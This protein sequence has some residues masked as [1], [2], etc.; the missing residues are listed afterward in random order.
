MKFLIRHY[1]HSVVV[2]VLAFALLAAVH[3]NAQSDALPSWNDGPAKQS[4]QNFVKAVTDNS[5]AKY[6][7]PQDRIATF[8]QDGTLWVEHP[9]Y[10]QAVFA[11][12]RLRELA[13]A[14]REW[15][16]R[17]PFKA[18]L[19][20]DRKAMSKFTEADWE[21]IVTVTHSGMGTEAFEEIVKKWLAQ[22]RDPR[23]HRPVSD[24]GEGVVVITTPANPLMIKGMLPGETRSY[25]QQVSV[26][27]LDDP[28]DQRYTGTL[29]GT[30]TYLGT[31]AVT[32]P[33]GTYTAGLFRLSCY[34]KVG[35]AHTQDTAYYFFAPG[36]GVVAMISQEDATAFWI[37]YIDTSSGK[38]LASK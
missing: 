29:N 14:H 34:G 32:V 6:V 23:W 13:P 27:A 10:T 3:A 16:N 4:I 11:L 33:A 37:I 5:S 30:Y 1:R 31:Y 8:D 28:T 25:S 7:N 15:K 20:G 26:V 22:A 12:D 24:V 18:V 17:E 38:V 19:A 21:V 36:T 35:P 2:A 9:I